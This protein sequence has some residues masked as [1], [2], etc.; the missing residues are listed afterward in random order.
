MKYSFSLLLFLCL[1]S[2]A[3][4][5]TISGNCIS[6]ENSYGKITQCPH[7]LTDFTNDVYLNVTS[8]I[9]GTINLDSAFGFDTSVIVPSKASYFAP[10]V[11][12]VIPTLGPILQTVSCTGPSAGIINETHVWCFNTTSQNQSLY[13]PSPRVFP[14]QKTCQYNKTMYNGTGLSYY[15]D[16]SDIS[17]LFATKTYAGKVYYIIENVSFSKD[18]T[19]QLKIQVKVQPDKRG[20]YD[21]LMKRSLDSWADVLSGLVPGVILD[22]WFDTSYTYRLELNLS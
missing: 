5:Y 8:Y 6:Y 3:S 15:D 21:L 9:T 16:W 22:P 13:C 12:H 17:H 1:A 7:T 2:L 18:Q 20:K 11:A 19:R 4:A 10:N 14:D